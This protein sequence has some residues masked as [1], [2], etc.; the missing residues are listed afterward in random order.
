M[1]YYFTNYLITWYNNTSI[2]NNKDIYIE[3]YKPYKSVNDEKIYISFMTLLWL[4]IAII[5]INK[6]IGFYYTIINKITSYWV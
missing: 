3:R 4:Q 2:S 6:Y 1:E 5:S